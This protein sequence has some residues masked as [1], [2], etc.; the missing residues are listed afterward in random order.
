MKGECVKVIGAF[1]LS[2][3]LASGAGRAHSAD[4]WDA[5]GPG[6]IGARFDEIAQ[7]AS[8]ACDA[9]TGHRVCTASSPIPIVFAGLPVQR[10]EAVFDDSRLERV[11][12]TLG[13]RRYKELL[14]ILTARFGEGEDHSFLAI[15]GMGGEFA[16]G[17]H[18]WRTGASS[19]VLEQYAGKIDRSAL[20]YGSESSMADLVRKVS[21][22]PRGARRDL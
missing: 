5:L 12:V 9:Q 15:A 19:L 17:V 11:R 1:L 10:I 18:V 3:L 13:L 8:L 2:V 20:T 14:Q 16:A 7:G 4:A 22:Y 6:R 21:L